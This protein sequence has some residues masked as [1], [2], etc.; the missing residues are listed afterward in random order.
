MQNV[1]V[2]TY[3]DE[4]LLQENEIMRNYNYSKK[5]GNLIIIMA[6][7]IFLILLMPF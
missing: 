1:R 5:T 7:I 3:C 2:W 4:Q 6:S